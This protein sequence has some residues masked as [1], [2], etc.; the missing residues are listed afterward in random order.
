MMGCENEHP[1]DERNRLSIEWYDYLD[2]PAKDDQLTPPDELFSFYSEFF[3]KSP[4]NEK[5]V[6]LVNRKDSG[7]NYLYE[8]PTNQR[9]VEDN[10]G[11]SGQLTYYRDG[12]GKATMTGTSDSFSEDG[13]WYIVWNSR[14]CEDNSKAKIHFY[15]DHDYKFSKKIGL[16]NESARG[17]E[18]AIKDTSLIREIYSLGN[19]TCESFMERNN[20]MIGAFDTFE[21]CKED[22][23]YKEDNYGFGSYD[24]LYGT[25][26]SYKDN[27]W[28]YPIWSSM[29]D[30]VE[31]TI[32]DC[33]RVD[34]TVFHYKTRHEPPL[35]PDE[36]WAREFH[37]KNPGDKNRYNLSNVGEST[38]HSGQDCKG[39]T[40]KYVNGKKDGLWGDD[41]VYKN[42]SKVDFRINNY[43]YR[44]YDYFSNGNVKS[45]TSFGKGIKWENRVSKPSIYFDG[46]IYWFYENGQ[47]Q[48]E[49]YYKDDKRDG[50]FTHWY[51]NGQKSIEGTYKNGELVEVIGRWKEDGS[52][53]E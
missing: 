27:S 2:V 7:G 25:K 50:L 10:E 42:G 9:W 44:N 52:V 14:A 30:S 6:E 5:L 33:E 38:R 49:E 3:K 18:F 8:M 48:A 26:F 51:E 22:G 13:Y 23:I 40:F 41:E 19:S 15:I 21:E 39:H 34:Y 16:S 32:K 35:L 24:Y 1:V 37:D 11:T 46:L 20:L 53:K 47:I 36:Y 4:L 29:I 43:A 31:Y 28:K 45:I 12:S 17:I